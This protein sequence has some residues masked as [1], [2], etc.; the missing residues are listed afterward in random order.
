MVGLAAFYME[1]LLVAFQH[2][3]GMGRTGG[4]VS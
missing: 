3:S 4:E 1:Y 2:C